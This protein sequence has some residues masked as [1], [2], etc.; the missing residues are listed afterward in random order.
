ML[1]S[2]VNINRTY[3]S[4]DYLFYRCRVI[5]TSVAKIHTPNHVGIQLSGLHGFSIARTSL[6]LFCCTYLS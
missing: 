5:K 2:C 3:D 1:T 4:L 6:I